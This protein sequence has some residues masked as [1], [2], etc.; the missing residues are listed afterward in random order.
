MLDRS[1]LGCPDGST[2]QPSRGCLA[3]VDA[4][5]LDARIIDVDAELSIDASISDAG[6]DIDS[7]IMDSGNEID[8]SASDAGSD[9]DHDAS[10]SD[11]GTPDAG[12]RRCEDVTSGLCIR[13]ENL[14]GMPEVTGW[15]FQFIWTL[16]T[17]LIFRLPDN[18]DPD[19]I[20][21]FESGCHTFRR[22]DDRTTE[23]EIRIPD[24][25]RE[26]LAPGPWYAYPIYDV[27]SACTSSSC[28]NFPMGYSIWDDGS[29]TPTDSVMGFVTQAVR[30]TPDGNRVVLRII[31]R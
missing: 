21:I 9:A 1:A 19:G 25:M 2:Y 22:I 30:P 7:S 13:F 4:S 12:T 18:R 3:N 6:S 17:G 5:M 28:P 15:M 26:T 31:P 29:L 14:S 27:R 11:A 8:A 20:P 24:P 16:P 10:H 23:C